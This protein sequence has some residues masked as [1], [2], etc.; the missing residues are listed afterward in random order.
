[1]AHSYAGGVRFYARRGVAQLNGKG[2]SYRK[3]MRFHREMQTFEI[4]ISTKQCSEGIKRNSISPQMEQ[5][6]QYRF[7]YLAHWLPQRH[8]DNFMCLELP[9][10]EMFARNGAETK[11]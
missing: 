11:N 10:I 7:P 2:T 1:M 4:P 9:H 6:T 5:K 8:F 3:N